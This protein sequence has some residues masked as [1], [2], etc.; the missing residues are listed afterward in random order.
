MDGCGKKEGVPCVCLQWVCVLVQNPTTEW[1]AGP[2]SIGA[3]HS[4]ARW[5]LNQPNKRSKPL[6]H[7]ISYPNHSHSHT[8]CLVPRRRENFGSL[9]YWAIVHPDERD[10]HNMFFQKF[11]EGTWWRR[12]W[13]LRLLVEFAEVMLAPPLFDP[14]FGLIC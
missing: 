3:T 4:C 5:Q 2:W 14:F 1:K 7:F 8:E 6:L 11:D 12:W 10:Q 9:S 13:L